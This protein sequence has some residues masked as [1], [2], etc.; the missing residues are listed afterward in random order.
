M[1]AWLDTESVYRL[2]QQQH[3]ESKEAAKFELIEQWTSM[4][5]D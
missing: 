1:Q 2:A 3:K 5:I 4:D